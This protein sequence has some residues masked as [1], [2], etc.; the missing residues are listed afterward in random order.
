MFREGELTVRLGVGANRIRSVAV[1]STRVTLPPR[2]TQGRPAADVVRTM[3]L[4]FSICGKAQGAAAAGAI[5]AA[6][7]YVPDSGALARRG[8][9]VRTETIVELVTRL[10]VDWPRLLGA[11]PEIGSVARLRQEPQTAL[12]TSRAI[13]AE[14]IFGA[15]P[16]NWLAEAS[17]DCVESWTATADTIPARVL[18]RLLADSLDLGRSDVAAMPAASADAICTVLPSLDDLRFNRTPDWRGRPVET[19]ALARR[20]RHPLIA[21]LLARDGNTVPTRFVAQLVDLASWLSVDEA[22]SIPSVRQHGDGSGV[23]YGLAETARG[24]LLHQA[25]VT[26]GRVRRYRIIAPTEWNFHPAGALTRGLVDRKVVDSGVARREAGLLV[27]A[28]DP[29]VACTIEVVDA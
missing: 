8:D 16:S 23:G 22:A 17:L 4:L 15:E 10:L 27:Q 19:G 5:D 7:G 18:R 24:L 2:M 12:E 13:A 26:D 20:T 11:E 3:P 14:R 9:T 6:Q 1:A 29:C 28:L 25:E 21:A